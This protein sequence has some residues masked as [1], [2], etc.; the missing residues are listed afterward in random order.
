[1]KKALSVQGSDTTML[2]KVIQLAQKK[3]CGLVFVEVIPTRVK[4]EPVRFKVAFVILVFLFRNE[5]EIHPKY[6]NL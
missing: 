5:V 1:L 6:L 2:N 3:A 4:K